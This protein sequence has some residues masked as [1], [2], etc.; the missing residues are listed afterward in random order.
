MIT[1]YFECDSEEAS[2][3]VLWSLDAAGISQKRDREGTIEAE[4]DDSYSL[5]AWAQIHRN[6]FDCVPKEIQQ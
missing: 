6:T 3:E 4:F 5:V 2:I 1:K